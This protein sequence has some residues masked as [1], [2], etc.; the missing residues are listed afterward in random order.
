MLYIFILTM[1]ISMYDFSGN[2]WI[3]VLFWFWVIIIL[4]ARKFFYYSTLFTKYVIY[5]LVNIYCKTTNLL[6]LDNYKTYKTYQKIPINK[7]IIKFDEI[8]KN[9]A[10]N[11]YYEIIKNNTI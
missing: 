5:P 4:T 1:T 2:N 8:D 9:Y 10:K 7:K 3:T 6:K 11:D